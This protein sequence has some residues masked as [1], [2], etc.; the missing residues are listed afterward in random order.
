VRIVSVA[1]RRE[2]DEEHLEPRFERPV[3]PGPNPVTA[4]GLALIQA[5][6]D[7]LEAQLRSPVEEPARAEAVR[8]LRYWRRRLATAEPMPPGVGPAVAFGTRVRFRHDGREREVVL[9][10]HDEAAETPDTLAVG[11]P[12]ARAL[13]GAEAEDRLPFAGRAD[14]LEVLAVT[15]A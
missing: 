15:A 8:D 14:A 13:L 10:G 1:F 11:A 4:R 9:V 5:R 3:P 6:V 2:S 7:G 12:L